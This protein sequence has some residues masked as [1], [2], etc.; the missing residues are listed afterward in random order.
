MTGAGRDLDETYLSA[1]PNPSEAKSR[2]SSPHELTRRSSSVET[3]AGE[4]PKAPGSDNSVEV[5]VPPETGRFRRADR[6][7]APRDFRRV[8]RCGRRIESREF[9]ILLAASQK[10]TTDEKVRL[11]VTVSRRVGNAVVR[12]RIK[13]AVREWFRQRRDGLE[14][15]VDL[16]VIAREGA[17]CVSAGGIAK[18]LDRMLSLPQETER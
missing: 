11:G 3:Q 13:R 8:A 17:G 9:V 7:L 18:A 14:R 10:T 1:E 6:L 12:N 2:V 5:A 4:G 15:G 16:V